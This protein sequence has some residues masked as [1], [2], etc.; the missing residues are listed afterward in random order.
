MTDGVRKRYTAEFKLSAVAQMTGCANIAALAQQL[1]VRR[2]FLYLWRDQL[3]R[4]GAA[5]L[6]RGPGRPAQVPTD[7]A[8]PGRARPATSP[9]ADMR[10]RQLAAQQQRIASLERQLGQKQ[11]Q[12]EF[13]KR[14][15]AHVRGAAPTTTDGGATASMPASTPGSRA[16]V[17]RD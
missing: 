6:A 1:G 3:Q 4:G 2:K 14:T 9:V 16:K 13:F 8:E 15:F 10:D 5:A 7:P 12:V 17:N 11:E